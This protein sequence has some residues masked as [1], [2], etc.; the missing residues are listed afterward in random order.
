[1]EGNVMIDVSQNVQIR[2]SINRQKSLDFRL[3]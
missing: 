3:Y 2:L 1:V